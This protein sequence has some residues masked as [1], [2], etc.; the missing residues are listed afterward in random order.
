MATLGFDCPFKCL[1]MGLMGVSGCLTSRQITNI[2]KML[3]SADEIVGG[4]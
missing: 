1:L 3:N 2:Q 4:H